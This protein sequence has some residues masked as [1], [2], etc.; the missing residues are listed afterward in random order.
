MVQSTFVV[1][2]FPPLPFEYDIRTETAVDKLRS[3]SDINTGDAAFDKRFR[4]TATNSENALRLLAVPVRKAL[5]EYSLAV[6]KVE[7]THQQVRFETGG[8]ITNTDRLHKIVL[9]QIALAKKLRQ[10]HVAWDTE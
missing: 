2:R 9:A 10:A 5:V 7:L 4:V 3:G 6:G 8:L 1:T